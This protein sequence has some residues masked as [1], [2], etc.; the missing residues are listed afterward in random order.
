MHRKKKASQDVSENAR[1]EYEE[2]LQHTSKKFDKRKIWRLIGE[3]AVYI[4]I[5]IMI[6]FVMPKFVAGKTLV[7]GHSMENTLENG[8]ILIHEMVSYYGDRKPQR[9]DVVRLRSPIVETEFWVKRIIGLPGETVQ[10]K[11]GK[12]YING[13]LLKDDVYGSCKIEDPGVTAE[14]YV[15]PEGYYFVMGDNRAGY[16]GEM[17]WDS[18]YAE[19]G[20]IEEENVI[21]KVVFRIWPLNQI[22]PIK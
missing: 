5:F 4:A 1:Q 12:I 18:R 11:K 7:D 15:V 17:S 19:V 20:S 9:F 13:K 14:P 2:A 10:I 3:Y 21:A 6:V 16:D 8:D 22:G